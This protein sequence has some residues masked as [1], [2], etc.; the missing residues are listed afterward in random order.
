MDAHVRS[1]LHLFEMHEALSFHEVQVLLGILRLIVVGFEVESVLRSIVLIVVVDRQT[2]VK[3]A[4]VYRDTCL[5]SPTSSY[6]FDCIA[7]PT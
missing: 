3:V 1:M 4:A 7:S 2:V 6:V 5:I